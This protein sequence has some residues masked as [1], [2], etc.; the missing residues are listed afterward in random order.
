M[1]WKALLVPRAWTLPAAML[2]AITP[3]HAQ[4]AKDLGIA[5]GQIESAEDGPPVSPNYEFLPGDFLYFEFEISG[6]KI[7]KTGEDGP[8]HIRLAYSL[9]AED[10]A[11]TLLA[12]PQEQKIEDEITQ[13]DKD[14]TP[15]R[16]VSIL[17]PSY[18]AYGTCRVRLT[19][20]D[21]IAKTEIRR[22]YEF[23]LGG[24]K[25]N[26]SDSL[27]IQNVRFLRS[28]KD[29][30][31]LVVVDYRGG[32][33]VWVRFDMTGFQIGAAN[34]AELS[35]GVSVLRPDGKVIFQQE[36]AAT[37]K[38]DGLFYPPRVVPGELSVTTT[39]DL[40]HGEYS[41]VIRLR[42]EIGGKTAESLQKFRI[43]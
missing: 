6:Y 3:L 8:R 36:R 24:R 1:L 28:D 18:A 10:G 22:D 15:K 19:V 25:V 31:G 43:E 40:L 16:R 13:Q 27:A 9:R 7:D 32:D 33:T 23:L 41:L 21:L 14:W 29:G 17:L 39:P 30:P 2:L 35:Y 11:G 20:Q 26:R 5:S 34:V 12:P 37:Q 42:D 38:L 4:G